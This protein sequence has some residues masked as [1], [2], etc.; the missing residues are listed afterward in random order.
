M[1]GRRVTH[2]FDSTLRTM[3]NVEAL[4]V[5]HK[6]V[7]PQD[8]ENTLLISGVAEARYE[9]FGLQLDG[10]RVTYATPPHAL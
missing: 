9:W 3:R 7:L 2:P 4:A 6:E 5:A 1:D 10:Q 8:A